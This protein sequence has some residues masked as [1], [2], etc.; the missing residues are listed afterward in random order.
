M[1]KM[2]VDPFLVIW[3]VDPQ[4]SPECCREEGSCVNF[5]RSIDQI[6]RITISTTAEGREANIVISL[7]SDKFMLDGTGSCLGL[8]VCHLCLY[9][10]GVKPPSAYPVLL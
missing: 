10:V 6:P 9:S 3:V 5:M 1:E 7:L 4:T 2:V 8:H